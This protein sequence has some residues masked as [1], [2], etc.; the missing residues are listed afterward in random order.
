ME[1]IIRDDGRGV[2]IDKIYTLAIEKEIYAADSERPSDADIANLIFSSGFSTAD[3]VSDVSG[4]GVGM[5]AV[6]T[7]L[8][9][10][11][12]SIEICLDEQESA[13]FMSFSTV[14]RLPHKFVFHPT[15]VD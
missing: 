5:D 13:N 11:G 15:L 12:G 7:F 10:E 1:L 2:A 3:T 4:R 8:E 14:I 6:K 9:Q